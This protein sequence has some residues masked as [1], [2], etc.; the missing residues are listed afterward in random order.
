M[1][2]NQDIYMN[3]SIF[4]P[5]ETA[6]NRPFIYGFTQAAILHRRIISTFPWVNDDISIFLSIAVRQKT[7]WKHIV[8][9]NGSFYFRRAEMCIRDSPNPL[10]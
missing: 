9:L 1:F 7:E 3:T 6:Q 4:F 10:P 8:R 2:I 5:S